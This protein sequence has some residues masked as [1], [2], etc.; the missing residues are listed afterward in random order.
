MFLQQ[1][2][3]KGEEKDVCNRIDIWSSLW[4]G[5]N[6]EF[7]KFLVKDPNLCWLSRKIFHV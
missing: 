6:A 5:K 3:W 7:E 4:K 2:N 1:I